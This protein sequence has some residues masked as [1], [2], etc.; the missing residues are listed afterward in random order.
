[1]HEATI[2]QSI[3]DIAATKLEQ[4]P[5]ARCILAVR[6]KV[7]EFRNV[8]GDSLAFAFDGLKHLYRGLATCKL[9]LEP[10]KALAWCNKGKHQYNPS[11]DLG[12][13]CDR[14]GSGIGQLICGEELEVVKITMKACPTEENRKSCMSQSMS[15]R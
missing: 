7:G 15:T 9:E 3:L 14:C 6:I 13:C 11:F 8:D 10:I 12:F 4:T 1:M 5:E 2:A